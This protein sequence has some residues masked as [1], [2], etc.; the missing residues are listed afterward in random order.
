MIFIHIYNKNIVS[1][2]S[3]FTQFQ[4]ENLKTYLIKGLSD[5]QVFMVP[6]GFPENVKTSQLSPHSLPCPASV[7]P[8]VLISHQFQV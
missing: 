1:S 4:S 2:N 7:C 3:F 8:P 6:H 5:L